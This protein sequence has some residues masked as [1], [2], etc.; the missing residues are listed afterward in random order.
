MAGAGAG[1]LSD[2]ID[3]ALN[4]RI[5]S[6]EF[7]STPSPPNCKVFIANVS[8]DVLCVYAAVTTLYHV[9]SIA[10]ETL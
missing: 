3:P 10:M 6:G 7:L 9:Y 5:A 2:P 4:K 1:P 8:V